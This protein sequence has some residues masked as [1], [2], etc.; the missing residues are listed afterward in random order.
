MNVFIAYLSAY[1]EKRNN[2]QIEY[3]IPG[4]G[5]VCDC[6][7]NAAGIKYL[8]SKGIIIDKFIFCTSD[9][10]MNTKYYIEDTIKENYPEAKVHHIPV[11]EDGKVLN[12][13]GDEE[14]KRIEKGDNIYLDITGGF[15]DAVYTLSLITRFF[16]F[17]G[18]EIK[19]IIYSKKI[20]DKNEGFITDYTDNFNAMNL[21]N[22]VNEVMSFGS[23]KTLCK[24]FKNTNN[25]YIKNLLDAMESF[26]DVI[27]LGI[28]GKVDERLDDLYKAIDD[29]ETNDSTEDTDDRLVLG[30][31]ILKTLTAQIKDKF[32]AS[33]G[34]PDYVSIIKWCVEN[35]LIQQGITL[36]I[37]RIDSMI[38]DTIVENIGNVKANNNDTVFYSV[39][40][41]VDLGSDEMK[42][43]KK[44]CENSVCTSPWD[45][46]SRKFKKPAGMDEGSE[47]MKIGKKRFVNLLRYCYE[48][49]DGNLAKIRADQYLKGG[50]SRWDNETKAAW[51]EIMRQNNIKT[52]GANMNNDIY[53]L[54][55]GLPVKG[56]NKN[57][58]QGEKHAETME[59]RVA[60]LKKFEL[61]AARPEFKIKCSIDRMRVIAG[62]YIYFKAVRN[63]INH[64][65]EEDNLNSEQI[66]YF[67]NSLELK[68][69]LT[70][71]NLSSQ[72]LDAMEKI[73]T[74]ANAL[75]E[76]EE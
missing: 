20:N 56:T 5:T 22:G 10:A 14:F 65:G 2:S 33:N 29:F 9:G 61:V 32:F 8:K 45:S 12:V 34:K 23:S 54:L 72:L 64:A 37:E 39:F 38:F 70:I 13:F 40:L 55:L 71:R 44:W 49:G 74:T 16:E 36:Y 58:S 48:T 73:E 53:N 47:E 11:N 24:Y 46:W 17:K 63:R 4:G 35:G 57:K 43:L 68:Y 52:L 7:T 66:K 75:K 1:D 27:T 69:G 51:K 18:V 42:G 26:T 62:D 67:E 50:S 15:R 76:K 60:L 3:K 59:K 41:D 19:E 28:T 6:F 30:E 25:L 21:L 31:L